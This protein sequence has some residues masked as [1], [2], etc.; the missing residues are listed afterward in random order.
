[1]HFTFPTT[2]QDLATRHVDLCA[3]LL[4]E[5]ECAENP[6]LQAL[7]QSFGKLLFKLFEEEQFSGKKTQYLNIHTHGKVGATRLLLLGGGKRKDFVP[8]DVR[9]TIARAI[10]TANASRARSVGMVLPT[11]DA[12]GAER[13]GQFLVEG[14]LLGA[15]QFDRYWT[16]ERKRP[17][18]VEEV[19]FL[20]W[21]SGAKPA[22]ASY[23][24]P[25]ALTSGAL[26]GEAIARGV[27]LARDLVNEGASEMT[28]RHL[29]EIA[30]QIARDHQLE[31]TVLG[32]KECAELGM[33]LYLAVARGSHEEPRFLHLVYRPNADKVS[34]SHRRIVLIGKSVTFDS[35]GLA[36]KT[37]EGM[38]DMKMDMGGGATVLGVAA[39]L[40]PLNCPHEV[41]I[42]CAATEN[43]PSGSAYKLG[44]VIRSL[45]GKTVEI[46]NTDAEGRL[47]I[48]DAITYA[49]NTIKP[50][51]ILD[52]ATLTGA[53]TV[54][55]GPHVA[56][57]LS[58][59]QGMADR[60]LDA[61]RH[62][63]EDMWQL[64]LPERMLEMLKSEIAD[65]KN[66]ASERAGGCITAGLFLKEFVGE[67]PWVHVD[68]AGPVQAS[69][70]WGHQS[71]GATGFGVS[72]LIEYLLPR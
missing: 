6:I 46:T 50:D 8:S 4:F 30:A 5:G 20:P 14:A 48:A 52:F 2:E 11:L 26:R 65:F 49:L 38:M 71:K 25:P 40:R 62:V 66:C 41:H 69:K 12:V 47:T 34:P 28:P 29:V 53:C 3:V 63:G 21:I 39:A 16:G 61:A 58:N 45:S 1:M 54:A 44:D 56:G 43:M 15:Y 67:T 64:P 24:P 33:G 22:T 42:L 59:H 9:H 57:V 7:E 68:M 27:M 37:M 70:E 60:L 13:I 17:S 55:L 18:T 36:I 32:P 72:T 23:A 35:G 10:R 19:V 31:L 51:E